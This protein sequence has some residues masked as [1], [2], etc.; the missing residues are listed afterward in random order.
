MN[1]LI[2]T[3]MRKI[4][5]KVIENQEEFEHRQVPKLHFCCFPITRVPTEEA[6]LF[7][8]LW[9]I[10]LQVRICRLILDNKDQTGF[11]ENYA[12]GK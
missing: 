4:K 10:I 6:K 5:L 7:I 11:F 2:H 8:F 12:N 3:L 1:V 9:K